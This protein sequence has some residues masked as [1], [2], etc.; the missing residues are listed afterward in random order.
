MGCLI[1]CVMR[2]V[3]GCVM[4]CNNNNIHLKS[5]IQCI[6]LF[7]LLFLFLYHLT[8]LYI[9]FPL[10]ILLIDLQNIYF[11][12]SFPSLFII[13]HHSL[14]VYITDLLHQMLI[15]KMFNI[16]IIVASIVVINFTG[17]YAQLP[18]ILIVVWFI[19]THLLILPVLRLEYIINIYIND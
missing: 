5:N 16:L 14:S 8:C 6:L 2:C 1:G 15:V 17:H 7:F 4:W 13:S 11:I 12:I 10:S 18:N 9:L 19:D 3:M